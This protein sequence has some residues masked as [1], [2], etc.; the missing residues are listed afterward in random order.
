MRRTTAICLG[1]AAAA[2][3]LLVAAAR[4][5]RHSGVTG[6]ELSSELPGDEL[7]PGAQVVIDRATTLPAPPQRVWPWL[8]QLGKDRAGWYLPAWLELAIPV[9]R[10]GLRHIDA[11]LQSL[12]PGQEVP[13]W[14]PGD[15]VFRAVVVDPPRALV[16]LS[17]RDRDNNH[18]WPASGPPYP[19]SALVLSWAMVLSEATVDGAAGTR[20]HLRLRA[21]RIGNHA[22]ALAASLAGL[23]DEAT[24]RPMFAGLS[25]RVR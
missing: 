3:G 1:G 24:V 23:M 22:P 2:G 25:E 5:V 12:V 16:Y 15:P 19:P 21:N 8:V 17:A 14:G 6:Q 13:D 4:V 20:L 11:G 7:V 9:R 10:R 18:R